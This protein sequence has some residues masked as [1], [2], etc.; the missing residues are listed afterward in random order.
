MP[1]APLSNYQNAVIDRY[2]SNDGTPDYEKSWSYLDK[3][4]NREIVKA[5]GLLV[6]NAV[7]IAI[8]APVTNADA[9][10]ARN[11]A[12]PARSSGVPQRPAGVRRRMRSWRPDTCWRASRVSSVSIQPGSTALTWMLS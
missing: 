5:G 2:K 4:I 8:A 1:M 9:A 6:F 11:T 7:L 3:I 10:P 12:I